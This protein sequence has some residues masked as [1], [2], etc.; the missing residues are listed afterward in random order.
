MKVVLE[1]QWRLIVQSNKAGGIR[2]WDWERI[3]GQSWPFWLGKVNDVPKPL[4]YILVTTVFSSFIHWGWWCLCFEIIVKIT[5]ISRYYLACHIIGP[6]EMVAPDAVLSFTLPCWPQ[7]WNYVS[8]IFWR[9]GVFEGWGRT[10]SSRSCLSGFISIVPSLLCL[11][12]YQKVSWNEAEQAWRL[13]C[14]QLIVWLFVIP[15]TQL[16]LECGQVH[17]Y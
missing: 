15:L 14:H 9:K 7:V 13:S 1:I 3:C 6:T 4:V 16:T 8:A 10:D 17:T 11:S 12:L 5:Y 2:C